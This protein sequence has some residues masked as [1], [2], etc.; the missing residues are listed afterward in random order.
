M[1]LYTNILVT[2][3]PKH[4]PDDP[5]ILQQ[6]ILDL[7]AK[8]GRESAERTKIENLLREL[9]D[10]KRG[11]KSEQLS[12]DQLA[13]FEAVWQQQDQEET[14]TV[15]EEEKQPEVDQPNNTKQKR[16]GRQPLAPHLKR[17]RIVHDLLQQEK[18]CTGCAKDL[19]LIGEEASERYEYIPA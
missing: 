3:D 19:R 11:R 18:H 16:G 9:L 6:I 1:V 2:F 4:L 7:L 12:Q 10:A 5:Q 15:T 17:E 14:P 8:L 13:L